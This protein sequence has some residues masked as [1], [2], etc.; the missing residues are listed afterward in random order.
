VR[1]ALVGLTAGVALALS[2]A[3]RVQ[4]IVVG[5]GLRAVELDSLRGLLDRSGRVSDASRYSACYRVASFALELATSGGDAKSVAEARKI[6]EESTK[7]L[8]PATLAAVAAAGP[9]PILSLAFARAMAASRTKAAVG[10]ELEAAA[11]ARDALARY[12]PKDA[13]GLIEFVRK[14]EGPAFGAGGAA[15]S[16]YRIAL[17][18]PDIEDSSGASFALGVGLRAGIAAEAG[19]WSGRFVVAGMSFEDSDVGTRQAVHQE[20]EQGAGILVVGGG[21][22]VLTAAAAAGIERRIVVLDARSEDSVGEEPARPPW[23]D[24]RQPMVG[25]RFNERLAFLRPQSTE[26]DRSSTWRPMLPF[27]SRPS[28][29]D[30]A[31]SLAQVLVPR[32]ELQKVAIAVPESG[33]SFGLATCFA[34]AMRAIG[35]EFVELRYEPGRRDF[36]PEVRR[37]RESGAQALLLAGPAEESEEWL[38][39]LRKAKL[40]PVVLSHRGIAPEGLHEQAKSAAEGAYFVGNEWT[41]AKDD[42][43]RAVTEAAQ[44]ISSEDSP[45]FRRGYRLGRTLARTIVDGA[46]TPSR[47]YLSLESRSRVIA[48][49]YPAFLVGDEERDRL[50]LF[51]LR[52]GQARLATDAGR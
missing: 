37:F 12:G 20:L 18:A 9:H 26:D 50:S 3:P 40:A 51:V 1:L 47:L 43:E 14:G 33:G 16:V 17:L 44:R 52:G 11:E 27:V 25:V 42:D 36:S 6:L 41:P 19:P 46:F 13:A 15:Q 45:D 28:P 38:L 35:R 29:C 22:A 5:R 7:R 23:F 4:A 31:R 8:P 34:S 48:G 49:P 30:Q 39:A 24:L 2:F 21:D 32:P 10:G